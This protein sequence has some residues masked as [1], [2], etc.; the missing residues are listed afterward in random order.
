MRVW[1]RQ[2]K[3]KALAALDCPAKA[4]W[5]VWDSSNIFRCGGPKKGWGSHY[6]KKALNYT[7]TT[8]TPNRAPEATDIRP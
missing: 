5:F 4:G 8:A 7:N 6:M 1:A 2:N 3:K